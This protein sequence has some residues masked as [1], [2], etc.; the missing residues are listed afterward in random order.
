MVKKPLTK[1]QH[2]HH[3]H[4]YKTLAEAESERP[5]STTDR[6]NEVIENA[7]KQLDN[8]FINVNR[9]KRSI[10]LA[11]SQR[12]KENGKQHSNQACMDILSLELSLRTLLR[13]I[14]E[15]DKRKVRNH[16]NHF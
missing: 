10:V 4:Y 2:N 8:I 11:D 15:A 1:R 5:F 6:S 12:L 16:S 13:Q 14:K 9:T 3:G 7:L